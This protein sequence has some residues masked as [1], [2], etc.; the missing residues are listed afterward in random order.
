MIL[1]VE[2]IKNQYHNKQSKHMSYKN[3][4]IVYK[5]QHTQKIKLLQPTT[6]K[7]GMQHNSALRTTVLM[8]MMLMMMAVTVLNTMKQTR[9]YTYLP[10]TFKLSYN[11]TYMHNIESHTDEMLH[12][13]RQKQLE[14]VENVFQHNLCKDANFH[15]HTHTHINRIQFIHMYLR[16]SVYT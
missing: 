8:M 6:I 4:K 9:T 13:K 3:T 15:T 7:K 2:A 14:Y 12:Y 16:V 1:S 10:P 5:K 11:D